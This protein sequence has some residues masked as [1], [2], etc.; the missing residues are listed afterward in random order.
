VVRNTF[1]GIIM[2]YIIFTLIAYIAYQD[3]MNRKERRRLSDAFMAKDLTELNNVPEKQGKPYVEK[4][5]AIPLSEATP[6]E[7]DKAILKEVGRE[8]AGEKIKEFIKRKLRK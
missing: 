8:L 1:K 5:E 7:F 6:E 4:L 2:I 3:Y